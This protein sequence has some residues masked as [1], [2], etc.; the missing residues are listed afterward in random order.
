MCLYYMMK[1]KITKKIS[2]KKSNKKLQ[3]KITKAVKIYKNLSK[4]TQTT[5]T[6]TKEHK[7]QIKYDK[8]EMNNHNYIYI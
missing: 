4:Y 5:A 6:T 2:T 3:K 8:I 7:I 1:Y